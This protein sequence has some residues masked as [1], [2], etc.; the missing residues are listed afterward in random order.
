MTIAL[1][2]LG[3][4]ALVFVLVL[5]VLISAH[6]EAPWAALDAEPPTRLAGFARAVLGVYVRKDNDHDTARIT[7]L[8]NGRR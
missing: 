5:L 1:L 3:L 8:V 4:A 7:P 6:R 2:A